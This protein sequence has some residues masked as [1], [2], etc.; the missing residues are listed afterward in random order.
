[1]S[2]SRLET[3]ADGVFAI[4][5]TLLIIRVS[6][7]AS[8]RALGGALTHAWPQYAAYALSFSMIGTWWLNHHAYMEVIDHVD[9][10]FLFLNLSLLVFVAFLPFP[11]HLIAEHFHDAGLRAAVIVYGITQ[12]GAA[13]SMGLL[14]SHAAKGRRL[15][16]PGVDQ[17]IVARH[18]RDVWVGTPY[19][20]AATLVAL[21][22][23]YATLVIIAVAEVFYIFGG[24]FFLRRS[25]TESVV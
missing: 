6:A 2:K 3:F 13:L 25:A 17:R 24:T 10:T 8:G 5:A 1:M 14:W 16:S 20:A 18:T 21:W 9:R 23:P 7:D 12:T 22:S 4:A 15:I 19:C 11:T